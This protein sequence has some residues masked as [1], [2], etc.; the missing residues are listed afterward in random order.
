MGWG[1]CRFSGRSSFVV[2]V[3]TA[4]FGDLDDFSS[5]EALDL[6]RL[7]AIPLQ[8][9]MSAL[10]V[11]VAEVTAQDPSQMVLIQHDDMVQ[12]LPAD[13]ADQPFGM[14]AN[15]RRSARGSGGR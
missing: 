2:V 1:G 4:H 6:T 3:E 7:W 10:V 8:R 9:E 12:T 11:V 5:L 13:T 14:S 15:R